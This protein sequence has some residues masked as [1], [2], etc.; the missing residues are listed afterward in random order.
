MALGYFLGLSE[1][2]ETYNRILKYWIYFKYDS[3]EELI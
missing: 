1:C 2:S 3:N